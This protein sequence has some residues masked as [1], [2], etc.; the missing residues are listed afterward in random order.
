MF[1]NEYVLKH[2]DIPV[3]VFSMDEEYKVSNI[4]EIINKERLPFGLKG[5]DNFIDNW[6]RDELN[7]WLKYRGLPEGRS[8]LA[9]VM[10]KNNTDNTVELVMGSYALNLTDHYWV[11]N[12]K[13]DL[14]WSKVNFFENAFSSH[15]DIGMLDIND[16]LYKEELKGPDLTTNGS[17]KKRWYIGNNDVR[18][19]LKEGRGIER[20]EPYNELIASKVMD[21]LK[22]AHVPYSV[23]YLENGLP[24]CSCPCMVNKN[25]EFIDAKRVLDDEKINEKNNYYRFV[26]ICKKNG[27]TD[28]K[29]R[30]DEMMVIDYILGNDD[31]HRG[32]F[33]VI[34]D[35]NTLKWLKIAPV[36][37]TGNSLCHRD[38]IIEVS[39][40]MDTLCRWL[41]M[42]NLKSLDLINYPSWYYSKRNKEIVNKIH[43]TLLNNKK[44]SNAKKEAIDE[45][46]EK[47]IIIFENLIVSK[48]DDNFL[49]MGR[50]KGNKKNLRGE[51]G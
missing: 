51:R 38:E 27:I 4:I 16:K 25:T 2:K 50:V 17:L 35:A 29:E 40:N 7:D 22:I 28:A 34:R 30:I 39:Q 23:H 42:S 13:S 20:Q 15:I 31:R 46:V 33:G 14:K 24:V 32:N 48:K 21:L 11:H 1:T 49:D 47:R 41:R 3:A 43:A 9:E 45:I 5:R 18:I 8:D 6:Y 12:T 36:F 26:E 10:L 44:M 37:D 19:M